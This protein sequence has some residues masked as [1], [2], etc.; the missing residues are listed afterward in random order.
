MAYSC[1]LKSPYNHVRHRSWRG[2]MLLL[3]HTVA[4]SSTSSQVVAV[5][6]TSR[7][8]GSKSEASVAA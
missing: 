3:R 2:A 4:D 6:L 1:F 5:K 8:W 7:V